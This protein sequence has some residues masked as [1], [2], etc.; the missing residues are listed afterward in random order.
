M[1]QHFAW[2]RIVD[3]TDCFSVLSLDYRPTQTPL[4]IYLKICVKSHAVSPDLEH[5]VNAYAAQISLIIGNTV[6]VYRAL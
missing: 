2:Q 5:P 1:C 4:D 3:L 6:R